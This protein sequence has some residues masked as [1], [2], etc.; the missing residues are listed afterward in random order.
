M[1]R[2][3]EMGMSDE[4]ASLRVQLANAE[5]NLRLIRE[6]KSEYVQQSDIPLQLIREE[7]HLLK[8]IGA[9]SARLEK[10]GK[11]GTVHMDANDGAAIFTTLRN[12]LVHLYPTE[13]EA[14]RVVDDAGLSAGQIAFSTQANSNWHAILTEAR[15]SNK[16]HSLLN[17]AL[18]E[19]PENEKLRAAYHTY[20]L[21]Q[22]YSGGESTRTK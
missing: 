5:E 11:M 7:R 2:K 15:K 9:L 4:V 14:R 13:A 10:L 17:V 20:R 16:V 8:R 3:S 21:R 18:R 12:V 22:T 6:R 1:V 19:Y